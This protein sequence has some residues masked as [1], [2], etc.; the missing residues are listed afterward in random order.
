MKAPYLYCILYF[1][2]SSSIA[3]GEESTD[4]PRV[5]E[6][7]QIENSVAPEEHIET[8]VETPEAQIETLASS[9]T[10]DPEAD[11]AD[12]KI[13][14][15]HIKGIALIHSQDHLLTR[16]ELNAI[17][18]VYVSGDLH[19]PSSIDRLADKL[20]PLYLDR[21]LTAKTMNQIKKAIGLYY[22][23]YG[24]PLVIV[25]IPKQCIT[26][27]VLQV[28]VTEAIVGQI[29]VEGNQ[30]TR[31]HILTGYLH[32]KPGQSLNIARLQQDISFINRNPFRR[33]NAI[34]SQGKETGTT[35]ITLSMEERRPYRFYGGA[36]NTGL[37]RTN[38]QRLFTGVS[39]NKILS[40]DHFFSYQYTTSYDLHRFRGNTAQYV[41]LLPWEHAIHFFGGYSTAH[42]HMPFPEFTNEARSTQASFRY[43][44]PALMGEKL[45]CTCRIGFDYKNTN[46]TIF[47]S[48]SY[49]NF[50]SSNVNLSQF[51]FE[52]NIGYEW[53]TC[54]LDADLELYFSPGEMMENET[55]ALYNS[56]RP[57]ATNHWLYGRGGLRYTQSLP[58]EY[59]LTI[60]GRAQL[61]DSALLP[62]EQYA[63]GGHTTVRG[64]DE[65]QLTMDNALLANVEIRTPP[66]RLI[67]TI[68]RF[69]IKDAL[70]F[71]AFFDYGF[72]TNH[73]IAPGEA[74][75]IFL[76][77]AGPGIRYTMDPYFSARL[78]WGW[79]LH[80]ESHA[81]QNFTGG[82]SMV[83][84]STTFSY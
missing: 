84:F 43:E 82:K 66:I 19:L 25:T 73:G 53:K 4:L 62:S 32:A 72:G 5:E 71:L 57:G 67:A 3:M 20:E 47:F 17:E 23:H 64:Y 48:E 77:S 54:R 33:V 37:D 81:T 40:L 7:E 10:S 75:P 35:D 27:G 55:P 12:K 58:G 8:S 50:S 24:Q 14:L 70:Q 44:I 45:H 13:I 42:G 1:L 74:S 65:N 60:W 22:R 36:D 2:L 11:A 26:E 78:D 9:Q 56:L 51:V 83:H 59:S 41:A 21:P 39:F 61:S 69:P 29:N 49:T 16:E 6:S 68:R 30:W 76:M 15:E 52:S 80:T 31:A 28:V 63:I 79:K 38:R 34:Y 46:S 18:G